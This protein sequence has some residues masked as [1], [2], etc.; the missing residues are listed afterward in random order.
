VPVSEAP[1]STLR[2][3]SALRQGMI[4]FWRDLKSK[5]SNRGYLVVNLSIAPLLGLVL[6]F[7]LRYQN[8]DA[9]NTTGYTLYDNVNLVPYLLTC[10]LVG[11]FVG[12]TVSA[13]EILRDRKMR[14]RES[15]LHLSRHSYLLAKVALLF[16]LGAIQ[17]ALYVGVGHSLMDMRELHGEYWLMLFSLTCFAHLL[18]LNISSAFDS[19]VTIYVLVPILLIPQ[20]V[21]SG[22]MVRFDQL[23]PSVTQTDRVPVAADLMAS[24]WAFE[25]L[26]VVQFM[27]NRYEREFYAVEQRLSRAQAQL[28]DWLPRVE[29]KLDRC[30][31]LYEASDADALAAEVGV[32]HRTLQEELERFTG[33]RYPVMDA[34]GQGRYDAEV[35]ALVRRLLQT[36]ERHYVKQVREATAARDAQEQRLRAAGVDLAA[37]CRAYHNARLADVVRGRIDADRAREADGQIRVLVDPVFRQPTPSPLGLNAHLFAPVKALGGRWVSTYGYNLGVIWAMSVLLY[38]T[39]YFNVLR[40]G[41]ERLGRLRWQRR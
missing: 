15:Y 25:G 1:G 41:I 40:R 36:L 29:A 4:F 38:I 26:A 32:L 20:I 10:I 30:Q 2:R 23:N 6:A 24:R 21:L 37:E 9:A 33:G 31:S 22:A 27:D 34:L 28:S 7:L 19:A 39:L 3:P 16:G 12:L 14:K 8:P 13:E 18:G 17:M 5:I 35:H 11:L